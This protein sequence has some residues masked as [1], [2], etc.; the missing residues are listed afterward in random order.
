MYA[1]VCVYLFFIHRDVCG[2]KKD[3]EKQSKS[4]NTIEFRSSTF[5]PLEFA[6]KR[7]LPIFSFVLVS[8]SVFAYSKYFIGRFS[9]ILQQK[10]NRT[11]QRRAG[12]FFLMIY[13][14]SPP[15]KMAD[16]DQMWNESHKFSKIYVFCLFY[17]DKMSTNYNSST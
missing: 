12:S 8:T 9:N 10:K 4:R 17:N 14:F 7:A 11:K 2:P 5:L 13:S 3:V 6:S 15:L 16:T 1:C